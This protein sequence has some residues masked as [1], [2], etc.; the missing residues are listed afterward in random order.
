[1]SNNNPNKICR[2]RLSLRTVNIL[3]SILL[4]FLL[5]P[6]ICFAYTDIFL[7]WEEEARVNYG[8]RYTL[9]EKH[10]IDNYVIGPIIQFTT[11]DN[12]NHGY[13]VASYFYKEYPFWCGEASYLITYDVS[14]DYRTTNIIEFNCDCGYIV[15]EMGDYDIESG[16]CVYAFCGASGSVRNAL[17][18]VYYNSDA[19]IEKISVEIFDNLIWHMNL[20]QYNDC[21]INYDRLPF[22][23]YCGE[24]SKNLIYIITDTEFGYF[25]TYSIEI[26]SILSQE[27]IDAID[28]A[29]D[30][31]SIISYKLLVDD[32]WQELL[33]VVD[34]NDYI[35]E[36]SDNGVSIFVNEYNNLSISLY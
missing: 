31:R 3:S 26:G 17:I 13:C 10:S 27:E 23:D 34:Y 25:K 32:E 35:I 5:A 21:F 14:D 9:V 1:M 2:L 16:T 18:C 12:A 29:E 30:L 4:Y 28:T 15:D 20:A 6:G 22:G 19:E 24:F 11:E 8:I 7:N 36:E 33:A